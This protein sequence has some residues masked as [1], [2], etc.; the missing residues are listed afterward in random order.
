[1]SHNFSSGS[2]GAI[3][4]VGGD[5]FIDGGSFSENFASNPFNDGGGTGG[6]INAKDGA[7]FTVRDATFLNNNSGFGGAINVEADT[8][9]RVNSDF[10]DNS[11]DGTVT[12]SGGQATPGLGGAIQNFGSLVVFG[13]N[14]EGN[15]ADLGGAIYTSQATAVVNNA[16]FFGNR[17]NEFG[18]AIAVVDGVTTILNTAIGRAGEGNLATNESTRVGQAGFGGGIALLGTANVTVIGG[19]IVGNRSFFQGGG[20]SVAEESRITISGGARIANNEVSF[21]DFFDRDSL[22]GGIYS[23]GALLI[24]DVVIANNT[25]SDFGGGVYVAGGYTRIDNSTIIGNRAAVSGGGLAIT[26]GIGLVRNTAVGGADAASGNFAGVPGAENQ[27]GTG[28]GI[29]V[30]GDAIRFRVDGGEIV[31]NAATLSGGGIHASA[32]IVSLVNGVQV[33][34]NRALRADGGGVYTDGV[35]RFAA[36]DAV[37]E[38]N[39]ARDGAGL[40]N[41]EG[42]LFLSGSFINDNDARRVAGGVYNRDF[43]RLADTDISGNTALRDADFFEEV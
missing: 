29:S 25:S 19:S 8:F 9:L 11:A 23:A 12:L 37:F 31:G 34:N 4:I 1:M 20:I 39:A 33:T 32:G 7:T 14:F 43:V 6:A 16:Q 38:D 41:N 13:G 18:G 27:I 10:T 5:H 30:S 21:G 26:G 15:R 36:V 22:G 42:R 35:T 2:G 40:F 3:S 24:D 28:G 17:V